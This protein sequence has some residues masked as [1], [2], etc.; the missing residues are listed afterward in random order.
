[1]RRL[2]LSLLVT[3]IAVLLI[4]C[5]KPNDTALGYWDNAVTLFSQSDYQGAIRQ[6]EKINKHFPAD[7]LAVPAMFAIADIYKN[8]LGDTKKAIN[9]YKTI[10]R[11]YKDSDRAANAHFMIGY[12]YANDVKDLKKA[13]EYYKSF[14]KKFP[15]NI[16]APSAEWELQNL[17]KTLDEIPE[18]QIITQENQ[19]AE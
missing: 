12:V 19:A 7:S 15:T 16:L 6:Y 8:N 13:E 17:G 2:L 18:L 3:G 14:I 9:I 11:D 4:T 5:G 1:M 10:M